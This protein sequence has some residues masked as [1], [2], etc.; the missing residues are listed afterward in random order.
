MLGAVIRY[1]ID[2]DIEGFFVLALALVIALSIHEF[3]HAAAAELQGDHT[4]RLAGRLTLNP[5]AHIDPLGAMA[6]VLVG[7]GWGKPVPFNPA[8]LRNRRFGSALVALA[9]PVTNVVLAFM[10]AALLAFLDPVAEIARN[11]LATM[12]TLNV[13]LAM[14]NLLPIPPLDGSRILASLLPPSRQHIIYFLDRWGLLIL[15]I[16]VF[17]VFR[18]ALFNAANRISL[19]IAGLF[20][21]V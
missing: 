13:L 8:G 4:A 11:F 5:A 17:F 12:L 1:L 18:D 9:G 7:F 15:F 16:G 2:G 14:F 10:A 21:L 3:G 19:L 20:G 6:M